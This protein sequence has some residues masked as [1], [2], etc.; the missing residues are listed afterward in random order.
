MTNT[1]IDNTA[2]LKL[3]D[4]LKDCINSDGIDTIRIATGFWDIPGTALILDDLEKLLLK[5]GTKLKLLIG[6]D[7]YVRASKP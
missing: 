1:L 5:D 4:T 6:K 2:N 3:V 7:P